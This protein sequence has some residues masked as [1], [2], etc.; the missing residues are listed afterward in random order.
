M[1]NGC[2][3]VSVS[4]FC[5]FLFCTS[6]ISFYFTAIYRLLRSLWEYSWY[7]SNYLFRLFFARCRGL[8][9]PWFFC[10]TIMRYGR[11]L[12]DVLQWIRPEFLKLFS[13]CVHRFTDLF[14][15]TTPLTVCRRENVK[16][17]GIF[18]Y[19]PHIL[20]ETVRFISFLC[21]RLETCLVCLLALLE[22]SF[23]S[24]HL[25]LMLSLRHVS[26]FFC[27]FARSPS[28]HPPYSQFTRGVTIHSGHD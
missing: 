27:S 22:S 7:H 5:L 23:V 14:K 4:R 20:G 21:I 19:Y 12:G 9:C 28:P 2:Q 18:D 25:F 6:V 24:N 10:V 13:G 17:K 11:N 26:V 8:C 15:P 1:E 16:H 3:R